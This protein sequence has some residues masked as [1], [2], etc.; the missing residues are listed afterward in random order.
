MIREL[1]IRNLAVVE[2][3]VIDFGPGLNV[4]TG[5]TGA[6]KS[7]VVDSLALLAGA[8][9]SSEL[10]RTGA[11][12]LTVSGVFEPPDDG[13]RHRLEDA[14]LACDADEPLVVRREISAEGRNRVYVN[15]QPATLRLLADVIGPLMQIHTQREELSLTTPDQ[16]RIWLDRAGEPESRTLLDGVAA[17]AWAYEDLAGRWARLTG[18]RRLR[19]ERIDLL[20]FQLQEIEAAALEPGEDEELRRERDVLRNLQAVVEGLGGAVD[21]LYEAEGSAEERLGQAVR[22]LEGIAAWEHAAAEWLDLLGQAQ[23][24]LREVARSLRRRLDGLEG[25]P[26]RLDGVENRLAVVERLCRKYG[27]SAAAVLEHRERAAAELAELEGDAGDLETLRGQMEEAL[28]AYARVAQELSAR[29]RE[30]AD[31]LAVRVHAELEDLALAKARFS[32]ELKPRPREGSALVLDGMPVEFGP[33]GVDHVQFL[34]APNPGEE[35]RPLAR[36]ASGGELARV[37]LAL[38]LAVRGP[39]AASPA[40]LVFDEVD[41]GIGGA[42][43]AALGEKLQR[44][45]GGGQILVVTHLAQVA[46]HGDRHL[47][48]GKRVAGG[49]TRVSVE[50]LAETARVEE[51]ARM[52]A[53]AEVTALSRSHAAEM[54]ADARRPQ[55]RPARPARARAR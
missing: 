47:R 17:L 32:I 38:Q 41:A 50:A 14:G 8:R 36:I 25:D 18:D 10:I 55:D 45:A 40:T 15:D 53:G 43:A 44:L 5:E 11:D 54:I 29:R 31:G 28:A 39:G 16:Q 12:L 26:G 21:A 33:H 34:F 48:V 7:M 20:R 3:S 4:L 1:H 35:A 9:A 22:S 6:G 30:W 19:D 42:E 2:E 51:I 23:I 52:L 37:Y 27:G 49:K 13:W 46:S 24:P